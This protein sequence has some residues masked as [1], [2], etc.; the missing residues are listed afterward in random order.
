MADR[1]WRVQ[2]NR[3]AAPH[4]TDNQ[5]LQSGTTQLARADIDRMEL[6]TRLQEIKKQNGGVMANRCLACVRKV[7]NWGFKNG[8]LP[9]PHNPAHM[10]DRPAP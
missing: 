9:E 1:L 6:V 7:Y 2:K 4:Q 8:Y 10:V 3:A 5:C